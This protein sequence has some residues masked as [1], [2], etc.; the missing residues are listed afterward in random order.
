M[1]GILQR[2]ACIFLRKQATCVIRFFWKEKRSWTSI[3]QNWLL[4]AHLSSWAAHSRR[5]KLTKGGGQ[6]EKP[7]GR[8]CP[9]GT[10]QRD[11]G[12]TGER[13]KWY[14]RE[15]NL[16]SSSLAL[17]QA[18]STRARYSQSD[19]FLFCPQAL[20]S[21]TGSGRRELMKKLKTDRQ[22]CEP[23]GMATVRRV[24]VE[25][26]AAVCLLQQS[27]YFFILWLIVFTYYKTPVVKVKTDKFWHWTMRQIKHFLFLITSKGCVHLVRLW[28]SFIWSTLKSIPNN[29][30][31]LGILLLVKESDTKLQEVKR[32][33]V[34]MQRIKLF[35][36]CLIFL[37][38]IPV[39]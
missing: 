39:S 4:G 27:G 9:C 37:I 22:L 7:K 21:K 14:G 16:C 28:V 8:I 6:W 17:A 38:L 30:C 24:E 10:W 26:I 25:T 35:V 20:S 31:E 18:A 32:V 13:T 19:Q 2:F 34:E 1:C 15:W 11:A 5:S 23:G 3:H 12:T 33:S 36:V 29:V